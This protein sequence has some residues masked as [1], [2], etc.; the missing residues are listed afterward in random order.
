MK[1]DLDKTKDKKSRQMDGLLELKKRSENKSQNQL[2]DNLL[3][4][5]ENGNKY[6]SIGFFKAYRNPLGHTEE[7]DLKDSG[8]LT[9]LDCLDGLSLLSHLFHRLDSMKKRRN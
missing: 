5:I 8:L 9:E 7:R 6:L 3:G 1:Q 2:P 4:Q